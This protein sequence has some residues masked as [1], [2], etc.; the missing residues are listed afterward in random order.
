MF[1]NRKKNKNYIKLLVRPLY[2]SR[3]VDQILLQN[4]RIQRKY[5]LYEKKVECGTRG[6][7]LIKYHQINKTGRVW[8]INIRGNENHEREAKIK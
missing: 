7:Q 4:L 1:T 2:N 3:L 5:E 6:D 8:K